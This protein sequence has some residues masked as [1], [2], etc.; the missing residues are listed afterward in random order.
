MSQI[1]AVTGMPW[2]KRNQTAELNARLPYLSQMLAAKSQREYQNAQIENLKRTRKLDRARY[3][4]EQ[5]QFGL[6]E[7]E[8]G[9]K[10]KGM[11]LQE[12]GLSVDQAKL[13]Q[14]EREFG[15]SQEQANKARDYQKDVEQRQMGIGA[16]GLG[17]TAMSGLG[18]G[19]SFGDLTAGAKN[20]W[21][22]LSG[23]SGAP[24]EIPSTGGL[25]GMNLGS[26]F[27][28]GLIGFG[29]GQAF[30][31]Q[32]KLKKTAIG[33]GIGG[34]ASMLGSGGDWGAGIGGG[35]LGGLGGMLF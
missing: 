5:K 8:F 19:T 14:S 30:G 4:L 2:L 27:G 16:A 6:A 20:L 9:L 1:G 15:W 10:E 28:G 18:K 32:S 34:I 35:L 21:N 13:A 25:S 12:K 3:G 33:A 17:F 11:E 31:G 26:M 22:S 29:A 23:N 7:E 24:K